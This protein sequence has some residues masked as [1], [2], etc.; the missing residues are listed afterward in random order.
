MPQVREAD[1]HGGARIQHRQQVP[2]DGGPVPTSPCGND[3]RERVLSHLPA[4]TGPRESC[5]LN[6]TP[7]FNA[8]P[9]QRQGDVGPA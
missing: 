9:A 4:G 2:H 7:S 6:L 3:V 8:G 5:A 1:Q